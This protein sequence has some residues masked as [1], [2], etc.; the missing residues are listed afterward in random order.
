MLMSSIALICNAL[1][2]F[3]AVAVARVFP[4]NQKNIFKAA[5]VK[6]LGLIL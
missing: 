3:W 6:I 2:Q 5:N 4:V 1:A